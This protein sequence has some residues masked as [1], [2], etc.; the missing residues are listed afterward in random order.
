MVGVNPGPEESPTR[1]NE[2]FRSGIVYAQIDTVAPEWTFKTI[3]SDNFATYFVGAGENKSQASAKVASFE[4]AAIEGVRWLKD[5][6]AFPGQPDTPPQLLDM[7]KHSAEVADTWF[8]YDRSKSVYRYY[9]SLRLPN[10]FRKLDIKSLVPIFVSLPN[11]SAVRVADAGLILLLKHMGHAPVSADLYVLSGDVEG[12]DAI[13]PYSNDRK[14]AELHVTK[15]KAFMPSCSGGPAEVSGYAIW[16]FHVDSLKISRKFE[17][18][19]NLGIVA[20]DGRRFD[21]FAVDF[22]YSKPV[23]GIEIRV[24][25]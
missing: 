6:Q 24:A 22:S 17:K 20:S 7:V 2:L 1:S 15:F 10:D 21:L 25:R 19:Q 3:Q 5:D 12:A 8:I 16:C 23:I 9:T 18:A 13:E 11:D 4:N 14:L